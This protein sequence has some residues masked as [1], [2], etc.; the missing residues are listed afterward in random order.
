VSLF[1][2]FDRDD[3]GLIDES[4]FKTILDALGWDSSQETRS[5]EFAAIDGDGDG[6]VDMRE[7]ANWWQDRN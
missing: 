5:L 4:E 3:D 7:F 6:R 1:R 2:Q